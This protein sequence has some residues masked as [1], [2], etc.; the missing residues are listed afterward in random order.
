LF[1][2]I[3]YPPGNVGDFAPIV[4]RLKLN[5]VDLFLQ[6]TTAPDGL[7]ILQAVKALDYNPIAM[8]HVIGAPYTADFAAGAK[9]DAN[10]ITDAVGYV[11]ELASSNPKISAFGRL[12]KATYN[13]DL[14]DQASLGTNGVGVLYAA[15]ERAASLDRAAV[16]TAIRE[17][18]LQ[19]GAN[20]YIIRDGVKFSAEG[21]NMRARALVMQILNQQ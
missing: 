18:D 21:N 17:T 1:E 6:A 8:L 9:E 7:Q 4:Q 15:L 16:T 5:Q 12:Y 3:S 10:Y 2:N 20:P 13:R 19:I 14:D 11:P